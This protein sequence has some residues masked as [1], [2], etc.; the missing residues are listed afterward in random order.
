MSTICRRIQCA[1]LA[2]GTLLGAASSEAQPAAPPVRQVLVLQWFNRGNAVLDS[3]TGNFRVDLD[4][5]TGTPVN[6]VQIVIGASGLVGPTEQAAVDYIRSMFA[7]GPQPDLIVT[8]TGP[9]ALFA[10]KYRQQLFPDTPLLLTAVDE[11]FLR[12]APLAENE[13]A[14]AVVN[15]FRGAI[16]DILQ[17][18]PE[19][20]RV[21]MVMGSGTLSTFWRRELEGEFSRFH[22]RLTFIW[23]DD[24][25]LPEILRSCAN[26]PSDSAIFYFTFGTDSHGGAYADERVLA[27]IHA[28]A[29]AP[30]FG[31]FNVFL[32]SGIVGGT[33]MAVDELARNTA[34]V[35]GRLLDGE[36]PRSI[37]LPPQ[38]RSQLVFDWRELQRWGIPESRLPPG[39]VVRFRSPSLWSEYKVTML[40]AAGALAVQS[41]LIVGLLYQRRARRRAELE[42]RRN[43]ALATDA[44]RRETMSALTSS[45]AHELGQP[46]SAM[47]HNAHALLIMVRAQGASAVTIEEILSDI[48]AQGVL[49]TQI[50]ERHRTMLRSR[51]LQKNPIDLQAVVDESLALLAHDMRER[52]IEATLNLSSEP[53]AVSGDQVLLQQVMVN[54]MLNAMDAMTNTPPSRRHITITSQVKAA[55]VEVSVSDTGTGLPEDVIT[56][57]FTPFVTTK[58]HGLGIGLMIVRT[59]VEAHGG[60]IEAR[61]NPEC[62]VTFSFTLRRSDTHKSMPGPQNAA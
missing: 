62:G 17:L 26:L 1:A 31:A 15:D 61:N 38:A 42:S 30:M 57:L 50:I 32:G 10:R 37:R 24:F 51:Q 16:G 2:C 59:I 12:D 54:L 27:E 8:V 36:S 41:L 49:A 39:S 20:K 9:A 7:N 48:Q 56:S 40:S 14:V 5:H 35:A 29:N 11:L 34:D 13:T 58:S 47:I 33:L 25:S 45:I 19:T 22:D 18:L 52:K 3:F 55:V 46:L 23:S 53:C 21:F 60:T 43:L 6:F 28:R 44:S 4:K